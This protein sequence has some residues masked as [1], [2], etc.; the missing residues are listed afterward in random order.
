MIKIKLQLSVEKKKIYWKLFGR[1]GF[2]YYHT[3]IFHFKSPQN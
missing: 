3:Y 2:F 1:Q